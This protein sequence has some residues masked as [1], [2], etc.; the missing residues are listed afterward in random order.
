MYNENMYNENMYKKITCSL[1]HRHYALVL[2]NILML[3][4]K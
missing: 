2:H 1:P 3:L 4:I